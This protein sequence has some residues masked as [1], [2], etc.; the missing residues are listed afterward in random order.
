MSSSN[1]PLPS[2]E[3]VYSP[4]SYVHFYLSADTVM[5]S[6]DES[7]MAVLQRAGPGLVYLQLILTAA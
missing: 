5:F 2:E 6:Q 3:E 1:Y 4:A 7:A